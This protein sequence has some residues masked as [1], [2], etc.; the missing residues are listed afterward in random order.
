LVGGS[1]HDRFPG[2]RSFFVRLSQSIRPF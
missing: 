2:L 1:G